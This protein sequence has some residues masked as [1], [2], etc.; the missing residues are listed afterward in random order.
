MA[1]STP[2]CRG[3]KLRTWATVGT[4]DAMPQQASNAA[5]LPSPTQDHRRVR[6]CDSLRNVVISGGEPVCATARLGFRTPFH[7]SAGRT[8]GINDK[9]GTIVRVTKRAPG[10]PRSRKNVC[11]D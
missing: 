6:I 10:A 3:V 1:Q 2:G 11:V 8:V 9:V 7:F 4:A 5:A